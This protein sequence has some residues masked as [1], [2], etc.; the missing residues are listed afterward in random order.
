M[1]VA[2]GYFFGPYV[3]KAWVSSTN[4]KSLIYKTIK[5][6]TWKYRSDGILRIVLQQGKEYIVVTGN[7]I[8]GVF[9]GGDAWVW[10]GLGILWGV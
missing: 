6:G 4:I 3:A 5:E 8:N 10:N 2:I 9:R 1:A 7:I